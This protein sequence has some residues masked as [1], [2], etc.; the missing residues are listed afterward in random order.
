MNWSL[1]DAT[2]CVSLSDCE[3]N[4]HD[5][6]VPLAKSQC[7]PT[8]SIDSLRTIRSLPRPS[9]LTDMSLQTTCN[10]LDSKDCPKDRTTPFSIFNSMSAFTIPTWLVLAHRENTDSIPMDLV[11]GLLVRVAQ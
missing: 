9:C 3:S 1:T 8:L 10:T 7:C 6:L 4:L 11:E 5:W 2:D